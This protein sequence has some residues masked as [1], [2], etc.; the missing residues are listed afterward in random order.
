MFGN[1]S[2]RYYP[3]Q[4]YQIGVPGVLCELMPP[5]KSLAHLINYYWML[6]VDNGEV[7]LPVIPDNAVDLVLSPDLASMAALYFPVA[8]KF[9]IPLEGPIIYVGLSLH[10][11]NAV[12]LFNNDIDTLKKIEQGNNTV[13][14]LQIRPLVSRLQNLHSATELSAV[15]DDFFISYSGPNF[16]TH[17]KYSLNEMVNGMKPE[18]V[19]AIA[20]QI[21]LSERQFRRVSANLFGLSPKKIQRIMRLQACMNELVSTNPKKIDDQYY[22]DSHRIRELKTLTGL[23][24][25][26]IRKMAEIYNQ[27]LD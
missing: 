17:R 20:R 14:S 8:E 12:S 5:S 22:D 7:Q 25:G 2:E 26:E 23:T 18:N 24:P 1:R 11:E 16:T 19:Q 3:L 6:N 9:E 15:L 10:P 13:E 4:L 27:S 21:G